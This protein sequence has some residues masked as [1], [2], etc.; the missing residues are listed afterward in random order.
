M[1]YLLLTFIVCLYVGP[2][3]QQDASFVNL[4]EGAISSFHEMGRS[5]AT[6][7]SDEIFHD[8]A[9]KARNRED[10][11]MGIDEFLSSCHVLPP[12]E[13][14]PK[15][16]IEPPKEVPSQDLRKTAPQVN[17]AFGGAA[18]APNGAGGDGGED[19]LD[20]TLERTGRLFGG[21]MNDVKRRYV[22]YI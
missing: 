10:L 2:V 14:D 8:V 15:I 17:E 16:R 6:L 4:S 13:W 20:P 12:G 7:M 9:Y 18:G 21:L 19:H 5:M 11:L 3:H 22:Y 1:V